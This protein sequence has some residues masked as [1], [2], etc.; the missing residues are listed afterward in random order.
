MKIVMF[1][2]CFFLLQHGNLYSQTKKTGLSL[3]AGTAYNTS[4]FNWS[5]AGNLDGQSPNI[6]SEL[7]FK[8]IT[9]L[10]YYFEA[11]Y[12]PAKH[13]KISAHYQQNNVISGNGLDTDYKDDNRTNPTFEKKFMS[14]QGNFINLRTGVGI[15]IYLAD[16]ISITPS[17]FYS[18]TDQKFYL[19][20]NEIENLRSTYRVDIE[21][22]ELSVEGK[23]RFNKSLFSSLTINYHFVN[24]EAKADWNLIDIFQHPLSFSHTSK[25]SGLGIG[26]MC[27]HRLNRIFSI[28]LNGSLTNTT[29]SKGVDT[30]YFTN[31]NVISTQFNGARNNMY[32]IRIGLR[33]FI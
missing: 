23:I 9:S 6:L 2:V 12:Y 26:I 7:K 3:E 29:I 28:I 30:S 18:S 10:G 5:I 25:G 31:K 17:L 19:L 24:Y 11:S 14:N 32:S 4:N 33:I 16:K 1:F 20:S 8:K 13:L 15:P 27:G 21:G 22:I